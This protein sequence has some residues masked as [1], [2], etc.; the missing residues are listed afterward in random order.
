MVILQFLIYN[1]F[2]LLKVPI[3]PATATAHERTLIETFCGQKSGLMGETHAAN[4]KRAYFECESNGKIYPY[5]K[6]KNLINFCPF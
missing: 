3:E 5:K 4:E 6:M 2:F 1:N